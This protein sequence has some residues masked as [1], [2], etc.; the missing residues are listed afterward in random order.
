MNK[1]T[2]KIVLSLCLIFSARI[3]FPARVLAADPFALS[4]KLDIPLMGAGAFLSYNS[5]KML[6]DTR[7]GSLD[8]SALH[9]GNINAMDRWAIGYYSPTLSSISGGISAAVLLIPAT[10]NLWDIS[11]GRQGWYSAL[12]DLVMYEE[13]MALSSSMS[14][15]FKTMRVHSTPLTYSDEVPMNVRT[16]P[17]NM[18]SF[19]SGHST[20]A[21]TTAAFAGYTFQAKHPDSKLV[22]W[23]WGGSMAMATG[24]G[25]L[26]VMSGKHFPSDVLAGAVVGSSFGILV[27]WLHSRAWAL[28]IGRGQGPGRGQLQK[29]SQKPE[30][31][32]LEM[33]LAG[34]SGSAMPVPTLTMH[35]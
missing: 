12:V 1:P 20:A 4:P 30:K 19:F 5:S 29:Q 14:S 10:T 31:Y 18:S 21:F 3:I 28:P 25:A 22:P 32:K 6:A 34:V 15:Y 11:H 8:I 13:A 16:D 26:R 23:V 33:G 27:P 24:V 9:R 2:Q 17:V 7:K 35:F